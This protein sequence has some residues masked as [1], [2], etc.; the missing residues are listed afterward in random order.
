MKRAL[1]AALFGGLVVLFV[2]Q[3]APAATTAS[4]HPVVTERGDDGG[5][6]G[7]QATPQRGTHDNGQDPPGEGNSHYDKKHHDDGSILF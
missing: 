2:P 7:A 3:A 6:T 5:S 1:T 4:T